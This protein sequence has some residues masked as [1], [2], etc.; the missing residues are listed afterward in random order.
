MISRPT[1]QKKF[2]CA[3][4]FLHFVSLDRVEDKFTS[5][6][7]IMCSNFGSQVRYLTIFKL[8]NIITL[9]C[10][11]IDSWKHFFFASSFFLCIESWTGLPTHTYIWESRV[12]RF[13]KDFSTKVKLFLK[14]GKFFLALFCCKTFEHQQS[15]FFCKTIERQQCQ[16]FAN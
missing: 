1:W 15:Q 13:R 11:T 9:S 14:L 3:G 5:S 6:T 12:A 7:S 2:S 8:K 10:P 16:F 4:Q